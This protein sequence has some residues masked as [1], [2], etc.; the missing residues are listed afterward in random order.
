MPKEQDTLA[1]LRRDISTLA[2]SVVAL[3]ASAKAERMRPARQFS[4][5]QSVA[6]AIMRFATAFGI[7]ERITR[8]WH[9]ALMAGDDQG[10]MER[11]NLALF[12]A[13]AAQGQLPW[14]LPGDAAPPKRP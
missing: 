5:F 7:S 6:T 14:L 1:T 3:E 13:L 2:A 9:E 12:D 10:R 8:E 4:Q 11:A